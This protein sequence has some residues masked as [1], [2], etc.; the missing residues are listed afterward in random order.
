AA[1]GAFSSAPNEESF[2][3]HRA[4]GYGIFLLAILTTVVAALARMPR[5][6]TGMAGL[7]AL[8]TLVQGVIRVVAA[9]IDGGG[10][11][12]STVGQ[13]V[14]GLHA[15]NALAIMG[16]SATVLRESRTPAAATDGRS[17]TAT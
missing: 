15:L 4:L 14:F 17:A 10:N 16:I 13:L 7:A 2:A 9:A 3:A 6:V 5:R 1:S 8:L 11:T 12:T